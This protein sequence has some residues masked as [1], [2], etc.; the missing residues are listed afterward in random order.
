[1]ISVRKGILVALA[2][3]LIFTLTMFGCARTQELETVMAEP[4]PMI[5]EPSQKPVV[6]ELETAPEPKMEQEPV[7][8]PLAAPDFK[9]ENLTDVFFAFDRSDLTQ[10]SRRILSANAKLLNAFKDVSIVI[11]GHCDERGTNE[12]NL[13]LGER[14]ASTVKTYLASLG[15]SSSRIRTI[16][17]GEE[18]PFSDEH[19]EAAWK[20]NRRAHFVLQ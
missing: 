5:E 7:P 10:E 4:E 6:R 16:S 17:Y 8:T 11:E 2:L 13:G 3:V 18:K 12:Y 9:V 1:M 19:N 20:Q 15:V 14:R